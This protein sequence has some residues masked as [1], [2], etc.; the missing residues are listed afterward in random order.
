[1]QVYSL[2]IQPY[3]DNH[4]EQYINIITINKRPLGALAAY[5]T[6]IKYN[7]LSEYNDHFNNRR[8]TPLCVYAVKNI[9]G[10]G[11]GSCSMN[12]LDLLAPENIDDLV[13][14]LIENNYTID[15]DLT[16]IM[17]NDKIYVNNGRRLLFY[18]RY[19]Q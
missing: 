3:Y 6:N 19:N 1:M 18:I 14:F 9:Y 2:S 7:R 8:C 16:K 5:V 17:N 4:D 11:S 15:K 13:A 10:S 12:S